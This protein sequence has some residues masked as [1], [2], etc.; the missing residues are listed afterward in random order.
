V[1]PVA[2]VA[3]PTAQP[4]FTISVEVKLSSADGTH[5]EDHRFQQSCRPGRMGDIGIYSS[6]GT[7][8]SCN[9]AA[10][11]AGD[12]HRIFLTDRRGVAI[13]RQGKSSAAVRQ[14]GITAQDQDAYVTIGRKEKGATLEF[15][16]SSPLPGSDRCPECFGATSLV[17][18]ETCPNVF[19]L[20]EDDLKNLGA[21]TKTVTL[22][23]RKDER[24][25]T[26]SD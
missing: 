2:A 5:G 13:G 18:F 14:N 4:C 15:S 21:A 1:L 17:T 3:Q 19:E 22:T 26:R 20:S 11:S 24:S 16:A 6:T 10:M 7:Q 9:I 25:S 23:A 12:S 8:P